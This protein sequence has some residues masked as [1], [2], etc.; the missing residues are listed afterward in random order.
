MAQEAAASRVA[1]FVEYRFRRDDQGMTVERAFGLFLFALAAHVQHLKLIGRR[2]PGPEPFAY[3]VPRDV[4]V[5][6]LAQYDSLRRP[7]RVLPALARGVRGSWRALDDV[8][9]VWALGPSPL[10]VVIAF[11]G[12]LRRKRVVLGVRQDT[13]AY[14]RSR[15]PGRRG[16]RLAA[17]VLQWCF[18]MLARRCPVVVVGDDL[19]RHYEQAPAVHVLHVSLVSDHEV[20]D[21]DPPGRATFGGR[22][23][24][25]GRLDAE[26]NSLLLADVLAQLNADGED[27]T[28]DVYGDGPLSEDLEQRG[29]ELGLAEALRLHGYVPADDG[30]FD[31]YREAD[32]FLH[33]SWTEGMPQVLLEAFAARLPTV[34]TA[35][36]G[37][38]AL[39]DDAALLVEPGDAAA[40][41]SAL[42]RLAAEPALRA[43]LADAAERVVRDHTTERE[44]QRLVQFLVG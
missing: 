24:T 17:S 5:V 2:D 7:W 12:L 21:A 8:D 31:V 22:L 3:R 15:H 33:V 32:A 6:G 37:V 42:R 18:G 41:A 14:V 20:L 29:S 13:E 4:Q 25:V 27:W 35:V 36:G 16:M 28:L 26:K 39:V 44:T 34:A 30:L 23:I 9:C 38:A 19:V 40:A 11:T 1:V 10:S 43:R